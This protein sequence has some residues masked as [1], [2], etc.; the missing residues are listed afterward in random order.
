MYKLCCMD[1]RYKHGKIYKITDIGYN[2][3][4]IGSTIQPLS[5]RFGHH[6]ETYDTHPCA[7]ACIFQTYGAENCKITLIEEYPCQ[8]REQLRA[9]EGHYIE[10]TD[11]V[12]K[13]IA[14]GNKSLWNKRYYNNNK[15]YILARN[16]IYQ[17]THQEEIKAQRQ[18][19]RET[20]REQKRQADREYR[21]KNGETLRAKQSEK[22]LCECGCYSVRSSI[23]RH[24]TSQK[25]AMLM[26]QMK[27]STSDSV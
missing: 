23:A 24:R 2:M 8:N 6:K 22:V 25:H 16:K 11:C 9:R 5:K 14:G 19:Y 10:T 26:Q 4:Y 18:S 13:F 7:S 12:N 15:E 20:H 1:S 17:N 3:C 27:S 21:Q